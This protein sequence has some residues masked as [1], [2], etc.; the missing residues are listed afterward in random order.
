MRT[1]LF[2]LCLS[3]WAGQGLDLSTVRAQNGS[4]PA[5][6]HST[7]VIAELELSDWTTVRA[8]DSVALLDGVGVMVDFQDANTLRIGDN[9]ITGGSA[10]N[11]QIPLSLFAN[12][13]LYLRF[14]HDNAGIIGPTQTDYCQAWDRFGVLQYSST[15]TYTAD[16]GY[17]F[18]GIYAAQNGNATVQR[19]HF[20]RSGTTLVPVASRSPATADSGPLNTGSWAFQWKFDGSLADASGN[21]WTA[22]MFD[23][24][25]PSGTCGSTPTSYCNTLYQVAVP[26][27]TTTAVTWRAGVSQNPSCASSFSQSDANAAVSTCFWQILSGSSL[28]LWSSHSATSPAVTGL[29]AGDY[30]L[31]L[32]VIDA[33]SQT[34]LLTQH[35]GV[36]ATDL[37][38]I[39]IN[40]AGL[41]TEAQTDLIL[42]PLQKWMSSLAA[43]P[44]FDILHGD[45]WTLR[46]GPGGDFQNPINGGSSYQPGT[47][48]FDYAQPGTLA[49]TQFSNI[50]TGSGTSWLS[51]IGDAGDTSATTAVYTSIEAG[52]QTSDTYAV[53]GSNNTIKL[54]FDGASPVT[55]TFPT[56][57]LTP[58]QVAAYI[59]SAI[60]AAGTAAPDFNGLL[61][62][63]ATATVGT[64]GS[65]A[66]QT[67]TNNA[68]ALLGLPIGTFT[69]ANNPRP[70][71][72][73]IPW[74]LTSTLSPPNPAYPTGRRQLNVVMV[75]SN[76]SL[77]I[78]QA[79]GLG[80]RLPSQTGIQYAV[81]NQS[82]PNY[83]D[84]D[85]NGN[86]YCND[87][88]DW[89]KAIKSGAATDLSQ[90]RARSDRW[91]R[92]PGID[93]GQE[94]ATSGDST[95]ITG[96]GHQMLSRQLGLMGA[97]LRALDGMPAY[98]AGLEYIFE[99]DVAKLSGTGS[100]IADIYTDQREFGYAVQRVSTCALFD[101]NP[102]ANTCRGALV[103]LTANIITPSLNTVDSAYP[104]WPVIYY[105]S[106]SFTPGGAS[107][108][109]TN[110][111]TSVVGT[112][113]TFSALGAT[114]TI[115]F[116]GTPGT[117]P[118]NNAAGDVAWYT[119]T[120]VDGTH[121]TLNIAYTGTTGCTG[122][123]GSNKGF[124]IF[125]SNVD[126]PYIGW[127]AQPFMEG[128]MGSGF[129]LASLATACVSTGVPTGCDNPTSALLKG[130]V[131]DAAQWI[132]NV[133]Y[134]ASTAGVYQGANFVNC[135]PPSVNSVCTAGNLPYGARVIAEESAGGVSWAYRLSGTAAFKTNADAQFSA[136]W[137]TSNGLPDYN[138]PAGGY[139]QTPGAVASPK[140][141]G[142]QA[143]IDAQPSYQAVRL[144][145][146]M[147]FPCLSPVAPVMNRTI[148]VNYS[149]SD[150]AGASYL[151][152]TV[153]QPDGA[154]ATTTCS[155]SPCSIA[156]DARQGQ[157]H[158]IQATYFTS[159][160]APLAQTSKD[161]L[162]VQ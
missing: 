97:T 132:A 71:M 156:G 122:V 3:A 137:S 47:A 83:Y 8:N 133:G 112:G 4:F 20:L 82:W 17:S 33:A 50:L 78:E 25:T 53:T 130:Y 158:L 115:W 86:Y 134:Q 161:L 90:A 45:Q 141:Y 22:A 48:Y 51:T 139:V 40:T 147:T 148:Y 37:N 104:Y 21:G 16:S 61:I 95:T 149:P 15:I 127:G 77:V 36:V 7:P 144:C 23:A 153:T 103:S 121:I 18:A 107:V 62:R 96:S 92:G 6:S 113:T 111:S 84:S 108:C 74:Y 142:L 81:D 93:L 68:Y 65:V 29:V 63:I 2:F 123:S 135:S 131:S 67:V 35:I 117:R 116:F 49:A 38:D 10:S 34:A 79:N 140:Y 14:Q 98:W 57:S 110:G 87:C 32:Q 26:V 27:L 119:P 114:S 46:S 41:P 66:V 159:G 43:Y 94:Y 24:S 5:Q 143:G 1:S 54:S 125:D 13:Y 151:H 101:P 106:A 136:D 154:T 19:I 126:V 146:G 52:F 162:T 138:P 102:Y 75:L 44:L 72:A 105:T 9:W 59:Q 91:F 99:Q 42:G 76:T 88:A 120:F 60:G 12:N 69:V 85:N 89:Y 11:F 28:P 30:D 128:L 58:A 160:G 157:Y 155:S 56:G 100:N 129:A 73:I 70:N 118:A 39:V 55:V 31:Q 152:I 150:I 124:L 80:W 109:V 64:G 145:S